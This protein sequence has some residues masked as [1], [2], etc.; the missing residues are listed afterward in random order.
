MTGRI[1]IAAAL[2][3]SLAAGCAP[4]TSGRPPAG[5][6][7]A[8]TPIPAPAA[9]PAPPDQ[10][11]VGDQLTRLAQELG[12]LQNA[13]ARLAVTARQHDERL[14]ML[15]RRLGGLTDN[16]RDGGAAPLAGFAPSAVPTGPTAISPSGDR[17]EDLYEAALAKF[18]AGQLDAAMLGFYE[19]IANHPQHS[20]REQAQFL[21]GDIYYGQ[22]DFRAAVGEFESLLNAVPR[23]AKTAETLLK[24]GLCRRALGD[25]NG[26]RKAWERL[27]AE[28]PRSEMARQARTL[29]RMSSRG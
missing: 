3:A 4:A 27:I 7:P 28:Y 16:R 22:K 5:S 23:G 25:E 26:A 8:P 10:E 17:P 21:V 12:D 2:L 11:K 29:L 13:V 18:R 20:L 14:E 9:T 15:Q 19:L 1:V 6:N 24:I